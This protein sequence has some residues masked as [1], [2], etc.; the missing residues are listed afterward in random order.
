MQSTAGPHVQCHHQK[1]KNFNNINSYPGTQRG[2]TH[3][4]DTGRNKRKQTNKTCSSKSFP[5]WT[6][7][8]S[9]VSLNNQKQPRQYLSLSIGPGYL[10]WGSKFFIWLLLLCS[11][12]TLSHITGRNFRS[13]LKFGNNIKPFFLREE[14]WILCDAHVSWECYVIYA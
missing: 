1:N 8:P 9:V 12:N 2:S 3:E 14:K 7:I 6:H 4:A 10:K 11:L 13:L 5:A